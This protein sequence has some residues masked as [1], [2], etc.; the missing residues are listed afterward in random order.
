[1]R[2]AVRTVSALGEF[3]TLDFTMVGLGEPREVSA[4]VVDGNYFEV[5][6]LSPV[7]GRLLD[8]R[9]DGPNA[10]G[11]VVLTYRFWANGLKKDPSVI[12]RGV[13]LGSRAATVVGVLEPSVPYPV[14]TEIIANIVTSPHHLSATMV[15]GREH[16]MTEV[17]AR[18]APG[19]SVDNARAELRNV[20]GAMVAAHP[21][22]Y[23][24]EDHFKIDVTRMHEQI[25]SRANTIL[26][27]LF[28]ASGLLFVIASS[29]VANL[30]LA[31]TVRRE[32]ELA[33]R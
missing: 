22:V 4:G 20:Y 6:G 19:A 33:V 17:F 28:A 10:A 24:P 16:R 31:R 29:N 1:L 21:A 2:K 18:L 9:D 14:A 25:N 11:A 12:G 8:A 23:K 30:V 13:R 32:S 15:T 26:W 7:L 3:S 5:M 27:I